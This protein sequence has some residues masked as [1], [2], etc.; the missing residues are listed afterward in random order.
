MIW[1]IND[2]IFVGGIVNNLFLIKEVF[3]DI[4]I[5]FVWD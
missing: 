2:F 5:K 4:V 3:Y 1:L